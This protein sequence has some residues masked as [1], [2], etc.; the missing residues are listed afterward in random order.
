MNERVAREKRSVAVLKDEDTFLKEL[1]WNLERVRKFNHRI[2]L[3]LI[4]VEGP[5]DFIPASPG[6]VQ[7][8]SG[9]L[10][11][12][13]TLYQIKHGLFAAIL[14]GTHEA[15]GEAAAL[16][17]K[18]LMMNGEEEGGQDLKV[19][20]GVASIGP[21][22][23]I[24]DSQVVYGLLKKD[25]DMDINWKYRNPDPGS[26]PQDQPDNTGHVV[27][28]ATD[29][30]KA[31]G[32]F[33]HMERD[34][35]SCYQ[36]RGP[37]DGVDYLRELEQGVFVLDEGL[38]VEIIE[39]VCKKIHLNRKLDSIFKIC[40]KT[41][42]PLEALCED[43]FD[44]LLP[45]SIGGDVLAGVVKIGIETSTLRGLH[46]RNSK[47]CRIMD[48]IKVATHKLNQPLQVILGKAE[49]LVLDAKTSRQNLKFLADLEE[50]K[51]QSQKIADINNKIQRLLNS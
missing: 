37:E 5:V 17:I 24:L 13:D 8:L 25:L 45:R 41:S 23:P 43:V 35:F 21:E 22:D 19:Y 51:R 49:L 7:R 28:L 4:H 38:P 30:L 39:S 15:G 27:I 32:L 16:R 42:E 34:G 1:D 36:A 50:L 9:I 44:Q 48:S 18:R 11:D 26:S 47:F 2:T 46:R 40:L 29:S 33:R 6:F 3:L 10:R 20:V 31:T 14:M 12:T